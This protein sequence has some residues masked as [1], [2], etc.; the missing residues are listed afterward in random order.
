M[1]HLLHKLI[2]LI[3][4][5]SSV[6]SASEQKKY[7]KPDEQ[8][9]K[10]KLTPLQYEVTQKEATERPFANEYWDNKEQGIYV[11]I[12]SGEPLFSSKDKFDS[13]TGW[14]SFTNPVNAEFIVLREDNKLWQKRVEVRSKYA[15][16]HL[17]H[18]FDDGPAPTFKRYCINSASLRFI[19]ASEMKKEGYE[20]YLY[21]FSRDL[22]YEKAVFAGGC[23]WCMEPAF[24]QMPGVIDVLAGYTGGDTK[25]PTYDQVSK[26]LSGHAEAIEVT[27]DPKVISYEKLLT[28]F[29]QN[30]DPTVKDKQFCDEGSQYRSA[31]FFRTDQERTLAIASKNELISKYKFS[32]IYTEITQLATFYPA[33]EYHQNYYKKHPIKYKYYRYTCG[34]DQ[35]LKEIWGNKN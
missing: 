20:D 8:T 15:D 26:G 34:R 12:V 21:L 6:M 25:N 35:R 28:V 22:S 31:I 27:Y 30:I 4:L 13:G 18:V 7:S 16:S 9:I 29:W 23:F 11:D 24:E 2:V 5:G 17:G 14:P 10:A 19:P 32:Q 33:E 3:T 1:V